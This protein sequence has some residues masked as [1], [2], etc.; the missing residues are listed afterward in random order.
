MKYGKITPEIIKEIKNAVGKD[1]VFDEK[2]HRMAYSR[3]WSPRD[4][5]NTT[6]PDVVVR[7]KT[8]EQV[9]KIVEIANKYRIP[10]TPMGGL[11]GMGGGAV[12]I[13][14]GIAFETKGLNQVLEIDVE[15]MMATVQ[16]GITLWDLNQ[17]LKAHGLY[18]P[19]EPESK[20]AVTVGS[21]IACN[22]DSTFGI[23][24]GRMVDHLS[25][26]VIVT[27]EGKIVR[28]GRRKALCSDSGYQLNWLLVG[29][30]GTLGIVTEATV[31]VIP[32]QKTRMVDMIVFPSLKDSMNAIRDI[33]HSGLALESAHINCKQRLKFYTHSYK[34]KHGHEPEIP[35]W[36]EALLGISFASAEESDEVVKFSRDYAIK[37][38]ERNKGLIVKEVEITDGWWA[39][40]YTVNFTPFKQKW[41]DSQREKKFGAVD[42]G[43]PIGRI[44]EAYDK[45]LEIAK[46]YNQQ[47]LGM[48]IYHERP[49]RLSPSISFAV[50]NDDKDP[51]NVQGFY[52]YVREMCEVAI[53]LEGTSATYIGDS[54]FKTPW[55][56]ELEHQESYEYMLKIKKA[57]DPNGIMNPGKKFPIQLLGYEE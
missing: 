10:V 39:S 13:Y 29:A 17:A 52:K 31:K 5:K 25:N 23:R 6:L 11:T 38:C 41:P 26:A 44:E 1:I 35:D 36:A 40:K 43:I 19:H 42:C 20:K 28:V 55:I 50:F 21:S 8:T 3:D 4:D 7:P 56:G 2:V 48:C 22:N 16:A 14:G 51:E 45:F 15:N 34:E 27:G 49:N 53:K 46:K 18:F 54:E 57:F 12:P 9:A 33:I 47:I 37:I 24:H 32:I 30:E